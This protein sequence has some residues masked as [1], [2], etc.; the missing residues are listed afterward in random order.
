MFKTFGIFNGLK[1]FAK[2]KCDYWR[3]P[4]LCVQALNGDLQVIHGD[5]L[6]CFEHC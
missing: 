6:S 3:S 4:V 1:N 5:I 2:K